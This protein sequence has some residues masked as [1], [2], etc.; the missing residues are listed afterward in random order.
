MQVWKAFD[1][2]QG[3]D[4][5]WSKISADSGFLHFSE[6]QLGAVVADIQKGLALEHPNII[7]CYKCWTDNNSIN[8]ITELFT[9]GECSSGLGCTR[10]AAQHAV[11][12]VFAPGWS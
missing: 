9:S 5:A 11:C 4:V 6:E 3:I 10:K 8:L 2:L 1:T 12:L 7:K